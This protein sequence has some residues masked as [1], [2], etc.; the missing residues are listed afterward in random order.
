MQNPTPAELAWGFVSAVRWLGGA[1]AK[2]GIDRRQSSQIGSILSDGL[3]GE[4]NSQQREYLQIILQS[5]I[6]EWLD[7]T[8][9]GSGKL[10][11]DPQLTD[12]L[13]RVE[14]AVQTVRNSAAS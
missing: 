5:M 14:E 9:A 7:V 11:A 3:T 6:G 8:R 13:P 12:I 4:C 10:S 1:T 2:S